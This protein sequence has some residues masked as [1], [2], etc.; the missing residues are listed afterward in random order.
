MQMEE[1]VRRSC[2]ASSS[3]KTEPWL[4]SPD[5]T[6]LGLPKHSDPM[7]RNFDQRTEWD[8]I[9]ECNEGARLSSSLKMRLCQT[10]REGNWGG[11]LS[12]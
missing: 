9:S 8:D 3:E 2:A 4:L 11:T 12:L 6:R 1:A 10:T 7:S 5:E